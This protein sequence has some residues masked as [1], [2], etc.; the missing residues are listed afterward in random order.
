MSAAGLELR[1]IGA[2][3][4]RR[5]VIDGFTLPPAPPGTLIAVIGPNAAGKSTLLRAL[6]GLQPMD[7][8]ALLDGED[9]AQLPA[10]ERL[11]RVGYLP[12][13][14]PQPS[15]LVAYEALLAA[16]RAGCPQLAPPQVQQRIEQVFAALGLAD[17]ALRPLAELSGG[18][19]QMIGLA[20][21]IAREPTL[22]LLDEPTSALDLHWQLLV[23][24]AVRALLTRRRAIGLVALHDLNLALRFCDRAIVLGPTRALASGIP[25]A[26]VDAGLLRRAY[27][28]HARIEACSQGRPVVL[29]DRVAETPAS[30]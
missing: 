14:L 3:Y 25:V 29:V 7:G 24:D 18:Q 4:R 30:G 16:L 19:R 10:R 26:E 13:A 20:Q 2:G 5:R 17:L 8:Q 15:S 21:V 22:L 6:A 12:Q 23:L 28:V 9:L 27:G 1:G 11:N